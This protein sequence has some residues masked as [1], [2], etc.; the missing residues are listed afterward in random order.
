MR[1][2]LKYADPEKEEFSVQV[3]EMGAGG[4]SAELHVRVRPDLAL[5]PPWS[6]RRAP[7]R[8]PGRPSRKLITPG[9]GASEIYGYPTAEKSIATISRASTSESPIRSSLNWPPTAPDSQSTKTSPIWE[10]TSL[11]HPFWKDEEPRLKPICSRWHKFR[12][13]R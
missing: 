5:R 13:Q 4:A 8:L 7:Y 11:C 1:P 2:T 12:K 6:R 9:R 3:Y 10:I